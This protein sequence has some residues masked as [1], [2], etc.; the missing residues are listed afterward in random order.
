MN[1]WLNINTKLM[2]KFTNPKDYILEAA[3]AHPSRKEEVRST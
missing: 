3:L 2:E 1:H